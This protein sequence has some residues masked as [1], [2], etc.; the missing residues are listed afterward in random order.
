MLLGA[1]GIA[2]G[3]GFGTAF[4]C[5]ATLN[6]PLAVIGAGVIVLD[7]DGLGELQE[8]IPFVDH[9]ELYELQTLVNEKLS[10][11]AEVEQDKAIVFHRE[12]ILSILN[13]GDY[14]S[15]EQDAVL[16]VFNVIGQ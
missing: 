8:K 12:E 2:G 11:K 7:E 10:A 3:I 5:L 9:T 6:L 1:L 15:A 4:L 13:K 14:S 16:G